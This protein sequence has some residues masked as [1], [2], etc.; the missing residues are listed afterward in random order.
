MDQFKMQVN[1]F[2]NGTTLDALL[3]YFHLGKAKKHQVLSGKIIYVNGILASY[4][5]ILQENDEV[6][7]DTSIFE[8][9][10]FPCENIPIDILYEDDY[11]LVINKEAH[12]I[13][14]PDDKNKTG[15]L[16]NRISNYYAKK[17]LDKSV[18]YVHRIDRDTT[19]II[20]FAKDMFTN[21]YMNHFIE[22]HEIT[23]IYLALCSNK[24]KETKGVINAKIGEDRHHK[25]RRRISKTGQEA[26]TH[27]EVIKKLSRGINLVKLQLETGRTHQ[28]RVHL[29]SINHPLLGDELYFGD[30]KLIKRTVLHSYQVSFIHPITRKK[31]QITCPL[32]KDMQRIVDNGK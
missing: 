2:F 10:D 32:P 29:S 8:K 16:V 28:I 11:L 14:H 15:T 27:Y 7:I 12:L 9:R 30:C 24:F 3:D 22:K 23:R 5:T 20:I 6:I 31:I 25:S 18:R 19:G 21:A 1:K 17:N 4:K 13:V 26:I